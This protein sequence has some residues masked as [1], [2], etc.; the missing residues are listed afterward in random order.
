MLDIVAGSKKK[1]RDVTREKQKQK[2]AMTE[3]EPW[4]GILHGSD[5]GTCRLKFK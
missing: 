3:A 1:Y 5:W 2:Q 4:R